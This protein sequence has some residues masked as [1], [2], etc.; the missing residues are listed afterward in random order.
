MCLFPVAK[1]AAVVEPLVISFS[2]RS[3]ISS[4]VLLVLFPESPLLQ[5]LVSTESLFLLLSS[6]ALPGGCCQGVF[7]V[8]SVFLVCFFNHACYLLSSQKQILR[9]D[10]NIK[11]YPDGSLNIQKGCYLE[12]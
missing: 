10:E 8:M 11:F 1:P 7:L 3:P 6:Y 4:S 12:G 2:L 9:C 5:H